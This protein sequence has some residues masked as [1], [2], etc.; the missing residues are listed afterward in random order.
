MISDPVRDGYTFKG[1]AASLERANAG[2]VD[3]TDEKSVSNLTTTNGGTVNLYAVWTANT[4]TA[5]TVKHYQ[6]S[7][8]GTYPTTP[9]ET[10]NLTGTTASSVTPSVK[11][12]TGFTAPSTKTVTIAADGSTVVEYK[13]TRNVH[14]IPT[15]DC[16]VSEH[17]LISADVNYVFSSNKYIQ[18]ITQNI[19]EYTYQKKSEEKNSMFTNAVINGNTIVLTFSNDINLEF[20][21]NIYGLNITT[22]DGYIIEYN[23]EIEDNKIYLQLNDFFFNEDIEFIISYGFNNDLYKCNLYNE[24]GNPVLPFRIEVNNQKESII[25]IVI[26][27][28]L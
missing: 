4:N 27:V 15:Y 7:L 23:F 3:Y 6:M 18:R 28:E 20:V 12:Y 16:H 22:V 24:F 10:E 5:Y 25:W 21:E 1:W 14:I 19:L 8:D 9:T 17:N 26:L 2:T 11:S 13:Y